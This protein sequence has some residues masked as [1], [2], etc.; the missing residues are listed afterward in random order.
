MAPLALVGA[1]VALLEEAPADLQ[2]DDGEAVFVSAGLR[3]TSDGLSAYI[4]NVKIAGLISSDD[5]EFLEPSTKEALN[6]IESLRWH[7]ILLE[8]GFSNDA[9]QLA[10]DQT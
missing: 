9:A 3:L 10:K 1:R 2:H 5:F 7:A 4:K 8:G 6:K